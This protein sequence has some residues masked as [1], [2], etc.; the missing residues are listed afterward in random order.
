MYL[1]VASAELQA[2]YKVSFPTVRQFRVGV[3]NV[4]DTITRRRSDRYELHIV[5]R[6]LMGGSLPVSMTAGFGIVCG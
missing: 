5:N 2:Q 6:G 1:V 3:E 4:C